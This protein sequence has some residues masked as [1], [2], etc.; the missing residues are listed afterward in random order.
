[1]LLIH[2]RLIWVSDNHNGTGTLMTTDIRSGQNGVFFN[3]PQYCGANSL[4]SSSTYTPPLALQTIT[5]VDWSDTYK[6]RLIW[7]A[8]N[9]DIWSSDLKGCYSAPE[10]SFYEIKQTGITIND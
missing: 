5:T 3:N 4:R 10:L 7:T 9:D 6:P 2:S 8:Y 1:M